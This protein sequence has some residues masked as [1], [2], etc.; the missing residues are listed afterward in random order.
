[1]ARSLPLHLTLALPLVLP[2]FACNNDGPGADSS[3]GESETETGG[4]T[5]D[6]EHS[7]YHATIRRT[8]HGVAHITASDWGSL[9][10]GQAYA[11]T[12][13]KGCLLADQILKVRSHRARYH[14]PGEDSAHIYSDLAY[15]HLGVYAAAQAQLDDLDPRVLESIRGY[16][17]GYNH[18]VADGQIG[19]SCRDAAWLPS[20]IDATDLFAYYLDL[21]LLASG[22]QLI[23]AIGSAAP[24][25]GGNAPAPAPHY[26]T[27]NGHRGLLGSNGW[28]FGSEVSATGRGMVMGNPHFPWEGELQLW[29]SHLT[30]PGE[31]EVYGVGLLGVPGVLIGFNAD[32]AWTHTVSDGHRLTLYQISSPDDEPTKYIY[33]GEVRDMQ[34]QQFTIDVLQG[35]GSIKPQTRT[36]WRT[37]HGPMLSLA[38]FYWTQTL[39]LSYRDA[40]IDNFALIEQFL[41]M[42]MASSLDEFQQVHREV[43]GIPWVNTIAASADGRAWYMDSTPT[44]NLAQAAL[45][46][47]TE[48]ST[49]PGFTKAFADQD[50]WLL[51]GSSTRDEWRDDPGARS[52]GLIAPANL[53]ELERTDF[54]FNAND[55]HWLSNP[56]AP[57]TGY[58]PLHGF[59]QTAQSMRTRM[60][61]KTL[62]EITDGGGFAGADGKLDLDELT[63][64]ALANRGY[65]QE[66]LRAE[67]V[68]R[69]TGVSV[70]EVDGDLVDIAQ[71][72]ELLGSWDGLLNLDSVGAIIWRE[73]IGDYDGPSTRQQG[74]LLAEPFDPANPITTP[75]GLAPAGA[76]KDRSLEALARAVVRLDQAGLALDT[77]LGQAQFTR[78]GD[79][80]IPIHGGIREEGVTNL[81]LYSHLRSDLEPWVSRAEEQWA[82]TGLTTD[83][84]QIN[85]GTSF[86]MCMQFTDDG[87]EGRA[88]LSYSQSADPASPWFKDQ[89]ERF[90]AK[91]W[92]PMLWH[93]ADIAADPNL[94]EYEVSGD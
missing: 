87:P 36:L 78:K 55:S 70:W 68:A 53:P 11:F 82:P 84:Y 27:V 26:S 45:D 56:L 50:V 91:Q 94:V 44:P 79:A 9:A 80:R 46:A 41:R 90:S 88:L 51:D 52:P 15:L 57:L 37:H 35:D 42:N 16:A 81:M 13:D 77:P 39:A 65:T 30:I 20:T 43:N 40:N 33:E 32:V 83:G 61:A 72:C 62:L 31:F 64:A 21:G 60:N 1:M 6:G 2:I 24:L 58:S 5:G 89:T 38:P 59:E 29:E 69:C 10:F 7:L 54:V 17:S 49:Q 47:W 12:Q 4:E 73:W 74:A 19:D 63:Q 85:Y 22:R 67:L 86:I 66:L 8:S 92:R 18:A 23:P 34:A 93:E 48:R 14:G 75:S 28:A 76:T 3:A 25:G 71:A